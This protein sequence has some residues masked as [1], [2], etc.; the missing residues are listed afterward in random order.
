MR[1]L[2][3]AHW[4]GL[5]VWAL[6]SLGIG[7]LAI[8]EET[9]PPD[10]GGFVVEAVE[11]GYRGAQTGIR[12]G[13][14]LIAWEAAPSEAP[15]SFPPLSGAFRDPFDPL[16]VEKEL[17]ARRPVR[18]TLRRG[19]ETLSIDIPPGPWRWTLKPPM[20]ATV[21][22]RWEK[23]HGLLMSKA[24]AEVVPSLEAAAGKA[25]EEGETA[26]AVWLLFRGGEKLAAARKHAEA[27]TAFTKAI[28]RGTSLGRPLILSRIHQAIAGAAMEERKYSSS[29][30]AAEEMLKAEESGGKERIAALIAS[31]AVA[32]AC[33]YLGDLVRA[34]KLF[35]TVLAGLEKAAP[36]TF[37]V[38]SVLGDLDIV[39][40]RKPDYAKG[41]ATAER[42]LAILEP[43]FPNVAEVARLY[44][45]LGILA[46]LQSDHDAAETHFRR[47]IA[48][49]EAID[50][51]SLATAMA[52]SNL[53]QVMGSRGDLDKEEA[54]LRRSLAIREELGVPPAVLA[55]IWNNLGGVATK[56]EDHAVAREM[57]SKSLALNEKMSLE[58]LNIVGALYNLALV[59]SAQGRD[60]EATEKLTRAL[61]IGTKVGPEARETTLVLKKLG[62]MQLD[63]R[64]YEEAQSTFERSLAIDRKVAAGSVD[65]ARSLR[66]LGMTAEM[67]GELA[68][69]EAMMREALAIFARIAPGSTNHAFC[70]NSLGSVL[71]KSGRIQEALKAYAEAVDAIETQRGRLGGGS[72]IDAR[73]AAQMT[74]IYA[75]YVDLLLSL[76]RAE[77]AFLLLERSRARSLLAMMAE[78]DL[79]FSTD[80]PEEIERERRR[81]DTQYDR[82]QAQLL[83]FS[84][85]K[86]DEAIESA[87]STLRDLRARQEEQARELRKRSPRLAELRY[88]KPLGVREVQAALDPGTTLVSYG[89]VPSGLAVFVVRGGE[90]PG[91]SW[92][93]LPLSR[94]EALRKVK[95]FRNLLVRPR[96]GKEEVPAALLRASRDLHGTL[97]APFEADLQTAE[98]IL[99]VPDGPLRLLPFG[100][101]ARVKGESGET[102]FVATWKP[103]HKAVSATVYAE[104]KRNRKS[105]PSGTARL[106]AFGDPWYPAGPAAGEPARA[107][108]SG[109][110]GNLA[111][112]PLPATR[113]EVV[114]VAG[115]YG[116]L[117]KAYL[118]KEATEDVAKKLPRETDYVHFA[119]HGILDEVLPLNSGL[120][121]SIPEGGVTEGAE[122]GIL[123]AWE[124][125]QRIRLNADLVVLSACET[126]LGM[127]GGG[128][129][130]IGLTRAFQYAGARTVLASL[131]GV[132][133]DSTLELM[134][135]FY[136]ELR[137]GKPK[138]VALQA[139]QRILSGR[140]P[141][142]WAAF[143]LEGDWR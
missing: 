135:A 34:E 102:E 36:G 140:H 20:S 107:L 47:A 49:H 93:I 143:E 81:V 87:L 100:A 61:A 84:P 55:T 45:H 74:G 101:L 57:Y 6:A 123:Q 141:F 139:A 44:G 64:R 121:L 43:A 56:R 104:L 124:I 132:S 66:F 119:C 109:G 27:R 127:E 32:S 68:R 98:R 133:D 2:E 88:P 41:T 70:L 17:G 75:D 26:L 91:L 136:R 9:V 131:W 103:L 65:T 110:A 12:P 42:A 111:F 137:R 82:T 13:D 106:V 38:A 86:D 50:P 7:G 118:G 60:V 58:S 108:R 53:S 73:F 115:L 134:T 59:D 71:R 22:D 126:G 10:G 138:D 72:E 30:T 54:L 85:G 40:Q 97:L 19:E 25:S 96:A 78:R 116:K 77:E 18:V 4:V 5:C 129:G 83:R 125:F 79:V 37:A 21:A 112:S 105:R 14:R 117:A 11:K 31:Q 99:V 113:K 114:S 142:F 130:L 62:S 23:A 69:A 90:D 15:P 3:P 24:Y 46:S 80:V 92:K 29:L 76:S 89:F 33:L 52:L 28:E 16:E 95:A 122:N 39:Y 1:L 63:A 67:T 128:E 120:V 48:A 51:N 8:A 35:L 94:E